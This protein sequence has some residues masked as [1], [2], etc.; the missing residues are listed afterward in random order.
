[1]AR[2]QLIMMSF[3][4]RMGERFGLCAKLEHTKWFNAIVNSHVHESGN[5]LRC[6]EVV[7][8]LIDSIRDK[9]VKFI[10]DSGQ[11]LKM[12][13]NHASS[14]ADSQSSVPFFPTSSIHSEWSRLAFLVSPVSV[15]L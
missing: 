3:H 15:H 5:C 11:A 14:I 12:H 10:V 7:I 6:R 1:M 9:I 13:Q 2:I 4:D 8:R